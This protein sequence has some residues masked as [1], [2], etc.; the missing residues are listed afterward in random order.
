MPFLNHFRRFRG[1]FHRPINKPFGKKRPPIP[2]VVNYYE[3]LLLPPLAVIIGIIMVT[4]GHHRP[5]G[6][7]M[8]SLD[9]YK[10]AIPSVA[11]TW[12]VMRLV[13]RNTRLLDASHPWRLGGWPGPVKRVLLQT[14]HGVIRPAFFIL[15]IFALYFM[16]RRR[17]DLIPRY[18]IEDFPLVLVL[19]T[20]FNLLC[21]VYYRLRM[22]ELLRQWAD[23]ARRIRKDPLP[24]EM[25]EL[26]PGVEVIPYGQRIKDTVAFYEPGGQGNL[27]IATSFDGTQVMEPQSLKD[28][29]EAVM[30]EHFFKLRREFIVNRKAIQDVRFVG[31]AVEVVLGQPRNGTVIT[32]SRRRRKKFTEWWQGVLPEDYPTDTPEN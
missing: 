10:A 22:D 24:E 4:Y 3:R 1:V 5:F 13:I 2:L 7:F 31:D 27:S 15:G 18:F 21:W 8:R 16:V 23:W 30:G 11:A 9:F 20:G 32:A 6:Y 29:E 26:L 25:M 19:L 14:Y 17:P 12:A 28:I